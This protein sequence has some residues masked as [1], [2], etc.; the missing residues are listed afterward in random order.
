MFAN[1]KFTLARSRS[2]RRRTSRFMEVSLRPQPKYFSVPLIIHV[3]ILSRSAWADAM[4]IQIDGRRNRLSLEREYRC[5]EL[6]RPRSTEQSPLSGHS[7][8]VLCE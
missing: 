1:R 4:R 2:A 8:E 6:E 3:R 5:N 7:K